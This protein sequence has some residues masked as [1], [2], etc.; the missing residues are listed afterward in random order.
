MKWPCARHPAN[1]LLVQELVILAALCGSDEG[2]QYV[3]ERIYRAAQQLACSPIAYEEWMAHPVASSFVAHT[4]A[5]QGEDNGL[6]STPSF[7]RSVLERRVHCMH[8]WYE[9]DLSDDPC[10]AAHGCQ[11]PDT[12]RDIDNSAA[13]TTTTNQSAACVLSAGAATSQ[14]LPS[15]SSSSLPLSSSGK[16]SSSS[17]VHTTIS[18]SNHTWPE[19]PTCYMTPARVV[20]LYGSHSP[21]PCLPS[22]CHDD[23]TYDEAVCHARMLTRL[24]RPLDFDVHL[25]AHTRRGCPCAT[26]AEF[27]LSCRAEVD[28]RSELVATD[29]V[30]HTSALRV[31]AA[32]DKKDPYTNTCQRLQEVVD[33][34]TPCAGQ[35]RGSAN[36]ACMGE[37]L[38]SSFPQAVAFTTQA[39]GQT[40]LHHSFEERGRRAVC[41][42]DEVSASTDA[43]TPLLAHRY[44][45]A[46]RA[47]Q[48]CGYIVPDKSLMRWV[49][50]T[51]TTSTSEARIS[52]CRARDWSR[53][54]AV[55]ARHD[56]RCR[57]EG[58][59]LPLPFHLVDAE[60]LRKVR[61]HRLVLRF[62]PHKALAVRC[63]FHTGP[64]AFVQ[65][66]ILRALRVG[67]EVNRNGVFV[68]SAAGR[69]AQPAHVPVNSCGVHHT[70]HTSAPTLGRPAEDFSR[71]AAMT[72]WRTRVTVQSEEDIFDLCNMPHVHPM[73]RAI[74]CQ[75][76]DLFDHDKS[77]T[78]A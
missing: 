50:T 11:S 13:I 7:L 24:L 29:S 10:A 71:R 26:H 3:S 65:H 37:M 58:V 12:R 53:G 52:R 54:I 59:P 6:P 42:S 67:L 64:A 22:F 2:S 32:R 38:H 56:A 44:R 34:K 43:V 73:N 68:C 72:E 66:V 4:H 74:Y 46:L 51:S 5:A 17:G 77:C 57:C 47:L 9:T 55:T 33:A 8:R 60:V 62:V 45:A 15:S 78:P 31:D 23:I 70:C 40:A 39:A 28:G 36:T 63:L 76:N 35:Q 21:M 49:T 75:V 18:L 41:H 20:A 30:P 1:H 61:L 48:S 69:V 25:S 16:V 19:R 14:P 27:L